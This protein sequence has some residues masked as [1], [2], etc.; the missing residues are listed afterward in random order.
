MKSQ[1]QCL[2]DIDTK[3]DR[4]ADTI[5]SMG[6]SHTLVE[7]LKSLEERK[8][9]LLQDIE[10]VRSEVDARIDDKYLKYS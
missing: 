6:G 10:V 1:Q 7:K 8:A 4:I 3:L 5:V 9:K 2:F